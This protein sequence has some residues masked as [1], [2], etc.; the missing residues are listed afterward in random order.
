M[1]M[2]AAAVKKRAPKA[3]TMLTMK[4]VAESRAGTKGATAR[5]LAS[6][7]GKYTV[8]K[9]S[10]LGSGCTLEHLQNNRH[11]CADGGDGVHAIAPCAKGVDGRLYC[12][13]CYKGNVE[14][15]ENELH[16]NTGNCPDM[17]E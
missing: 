10:A 4:A 17:S 5:A 13:P 12:F 8:G 1:S 3:R 9:C 16:L 11:F 2:K 7:N 14:D 15:K 6:T